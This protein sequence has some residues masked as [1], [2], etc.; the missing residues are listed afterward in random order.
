MGSFGLLPDRP[1]PGVT[2][3]QD[4]D[5]LLECTIAGRR[6]FVTQCTNVHAD[7]AQ[8]VA[9]A[10]SVAVQVAHQFAS[11]WC[12]HHFF[13]R[14]LAKTFSIVVSANSRLSRLLSA[15]NPLRRV[16]SDTFRLPNWLRQ[17]QELASERPG[18]RHTSATARPASSS[19][20][21]P[22]ICPSANRFFTSTS[23]LL[24]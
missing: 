10:P 24:V 15:S 18:L 1:V 5:L 19:R 11:G 7:D 21:K 2:L 23:L 8:R 9:F 6:G 3:V 20:R 16:S 22:V 4:D 13:P 14:L 12:V 17:R